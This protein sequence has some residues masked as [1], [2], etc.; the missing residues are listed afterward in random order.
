ML[1]KAFLIL[2]SLLLAASLFA[3]NKS[4]TGGEKVPP[5]GLGDDLNKPK[6]EETPAT[7]VVGED[8][9]GTD[10]KWE[11]YSDETM[12]VTCKG[13]H[14]PTQ[15]CALPDYAKEG[16]TPNG[17]VLTDQPWWKCG[18]KNDTDRAEDDG[19]AS[20]V[21]KLIIGEG[22]T[23]L[24]DYAFAYMELLE[25]VVL[26][27][28]LTEISYKSFEDCPKLK[29][30]TGGFGVT[31]IESEAFLSCLN[32]TTVELSPVL[33]EVQDK[34][35]DKVI[36]AASTRVLTLRIKGTEAAWAAA[37]TTMRAAENADGFPCLGADNAAF[38]NATVEYVS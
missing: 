4:D 37:M 32:L 11:I 19:G 15:P 3:C 20:T 2:L 17:T 30:V 38:E 5:P 27:S 12:Y 16:T 25:E 34:A 31:V 14:A 33:V 22:I 6:E 23:A 36:P 26:P 1:K 7:L 35:F 29:T 28:T 9:A 21:K 18:G 8:I 10:L 13:T 24:G